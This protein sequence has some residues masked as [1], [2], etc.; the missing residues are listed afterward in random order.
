[1]M[2]Q[3]NK[4]VTRLKLNNLYI[5]L[6]LY[7]IF[8]GTALI[9]KRHPQFYYPPEFKGLMNSPV[10]QWALVLAGILMIMYILSDYSNERMTGLLLGFIAG[11]VTVLVLL[12]LEH[13][14]FKGDYGP[15]LASDLTVLSYISWTARHTS[16]R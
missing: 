7:S 13:W 6:G 1:M 10:F 11:L 3:L 4:L 5:I 15:A 16:K 12:E 9:T 14:Y 8:K 2:R